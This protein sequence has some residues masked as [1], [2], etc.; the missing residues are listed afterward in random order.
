M[1]SSHGSGASVMLAPCWVNAASNLVNGYS[2]WQGFAS[3]SA[4]ATRPGG[5]K[6]TLQSEDYA[7][8]I[9]VRAKTKAN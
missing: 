9:E 1:M 2:P 4:E 5:P 8:A 7:W 3:G 6:S